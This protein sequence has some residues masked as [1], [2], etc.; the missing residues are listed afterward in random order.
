MRTWARANRR[1]RSF[2]RCPACGEHVRPHQP[3][4]VITD[5]VS[6]KRRTYH[7]V[8]TCMEEASD[9]MLKPG[10][11]HHFAVRTPNGDMN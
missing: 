5:V 6:G 3:V 8:R 11:V 4:V 1:R 9:A 2:P 7:A 10:T